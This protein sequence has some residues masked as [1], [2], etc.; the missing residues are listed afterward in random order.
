MTPRASTDKRDDEPPAERRRYDSP[1]RRAQT[2]QTRE[3]IVAAGAELAHSF[4]RWDWRELTVRAVAERAGVNERTIYRHFV[5]ERD[6]HDAVMRRL[7]EEAGDPLEGLQLD[8]LPDVTARVFSYLSSFAMTPRT[9]ADPALVAVDQ[10]RRD[11]LLAALG[12]STQE[13]SDADRRTA[14]ALLDVLWSLPAYERL[15][16]AWALDPD[17]ASDAITGLIRL[18][19]DAIASGRRPWL[20]R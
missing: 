6:L 13:W 9:T 19:V 17:A 5:S 18:L 7:E 12:Q 15:T 8:D 11:A 3:R 20:D 10:R 2:A 1:V 4:P 14:A 16:G